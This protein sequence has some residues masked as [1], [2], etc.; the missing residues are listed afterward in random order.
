[1]GCHQ[2]AP[3]KRAARNLIERSFNKI[4]QCRRAATR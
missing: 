2:V 1:M 4:T 3:S